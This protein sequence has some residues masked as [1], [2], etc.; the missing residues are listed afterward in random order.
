MQ[1]VFVLICGTLAFRNCA[2][3]SH[4]ASALIHRRGNV[5]SSTRGT[6][7]QG[8]ACGSPSR[9]HFPEAAH[10][11]CIQA[12][13][14]MGRMLA[15]LRARRDA[16]PRHE[17]AGYGFRSATFW[18][19]SRRLRPP[20]AELLQP[21]TPANSSQ[22]EPNFSDLAEAEQYSTIYPDRAARIRA[23]G[24]PAD[25]PRFRPARGQDR[26]GPC[27]R[28]QFHPAGVRP[29]N[30]CRGRG[31][32]PAKTCV[33]PRLRLSFAG[34]L[35]DAEKPQDNVASAHSNPR[36]AAGHR[37]RSGGASADLACSAM[38]T[39]RPN[40]PA[41]ALPRSPADTRPAAACWSWRSQ[42]PGGSES[43]PGRRV[44]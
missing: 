41:H 31:L 15:K 38:E 25:A 29:P 17:R 12:A 13:T 24:R 22:I 11:C 40:S 3:G 14:M 7:S 9:G 6:A 30:A 37:T 21:A 33:H 18:F 10:R 42:A 32:M 35:S 44:V 1:P 27:H 5:N 28:H 16:F 4:A 20:R 34:T 2:V 26:R 43:C 8:T 36:S 23:P 19:C 39:G